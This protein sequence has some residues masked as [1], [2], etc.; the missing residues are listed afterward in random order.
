MVILVLIQC[1]NVEHGSYERKLTKII[2]HVK[3]NIIT[4]YSIMMN[5][6]G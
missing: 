6:V 5:I 1:A 4:L 2:A 3:D